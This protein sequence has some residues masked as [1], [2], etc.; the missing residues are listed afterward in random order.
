MIGWVIGRCAPRYEQILAKDIADI[1]K[2]IQIP[3]YIPV[4]LFFR[5]VSRYTP[6]RRPVRELIAPRVVFIQ[7]GFSNIKR[8]QALRTCEGIVLD[9]NFEPY[10]IPH[11]AMAGFMV[12]VDRVNFFVEQME[13]EAL[14]RITEA[15]K[16]TWRKLADETRD[17]LNYLLF[18]KVRD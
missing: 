1:S 8:V 13:Q 4:H 7:A 9:D 17:K 16:T 15:K 5:S 3:T 10:A 18:G 6:L 12:A 2:T 11:D 14:G